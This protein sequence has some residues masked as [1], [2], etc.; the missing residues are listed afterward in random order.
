[1]KNKVVLVILFILPIVT[2]LIFASA[3]HNSLFLPTL[4]EHN[5][6]IP[7]DWSSLRNENI[8]LKDKITVLGFTGSDMVEFKANMF[9]LNQKIY[10]KYFGFED[11]QMVMIAPLGTESEIQ[12]IISEL[13][14]ITE[15]MKGWKFV[16]ASPEKIQEYYTGLHLKTNLNANSGTSNVIILDKNINHRGRIGKNRKGEEEFRESYNSSSAADL[17]NEMTDDVKIILREYRLALKKNKR[18]DEFKDN[19]VNEVEKSSQAK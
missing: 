17:H 16:F 18:K 3:K 8:Q 15:D 11:F 2:Y 10:N 1:M 4:S 9:N 19:I 12:K 5:T 13:D 6:E 14:R 7:K